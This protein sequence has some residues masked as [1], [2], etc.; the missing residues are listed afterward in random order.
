MANKKT[1]E[2]TTVSEEAVV[3]KS[4]KKSKKKEDTVQSA[5]VRRRHLGQY[6]NKEEKVSVVISPMYRPYIGNVARVSVNGI[7]VIVPCD[8]KSYK[9]PKTHAEAVASCIQRIDE[10]L[11]RKDKMRNI[12]DNV[13]ASPGD[14]RFFN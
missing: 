7:M 2:A 9:I 10:R 4:E 8:G 1:E 5:E 12:T 3:A 11:T 13:E 14:I 6:Y